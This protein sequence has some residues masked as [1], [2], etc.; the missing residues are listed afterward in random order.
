MVSRDERRM[1]DTACSAQREQILPH[2]QDVVRQA[3]GLER[4]IDAAHE[5]R[6]LRGNAGRAVVR[7]APQ[8]LDAADAEQRLARD[9]DHVAAKR[10]RQQRSV[11]ESEL[12]GADEHH[13]VVDA[14]L[15]EDAEHAAE[16]DLE[17]HGHTVGEH[18]WSGARATFTAIDRDEVDGAIAVLE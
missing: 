15:R 1:R 10:E 6:I 13:A 7:V 2:R 17:R 5:P 4:R 16:A 12:A 9:V 14:V 18:Q 3:G 8:C 11:G